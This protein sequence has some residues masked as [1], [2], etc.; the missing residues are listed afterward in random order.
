[1]SLKCL[2]IESQCIK[3]S[4]YK[5]AIQIEKYQKTFLKKNS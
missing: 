4:S 3:F 2:M 5:I 1:M